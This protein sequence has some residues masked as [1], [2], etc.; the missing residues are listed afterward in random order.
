MNFTIATWEYINI[1]II[2]LCFQPI[3]KVQLVFIF[4]NIVD[5]VLNT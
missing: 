5:W 4:I 1:V 2:I 3:V